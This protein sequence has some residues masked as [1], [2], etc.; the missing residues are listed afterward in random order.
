VAP[1]AG[2]GAGAG[3]VDMQALSGIVQ[4]QPGAMGVPVDARAR[5]QIENTF[6]LF[7]NML[8]SFVGC[9][10]RNAAAVL[11]R[12][13]HEYSVYVGFLNGFTIQ[14]PTDQRLEHIRQIHMEFY[15]NVLYEM[16]VGIQQG[17]LTK[18]EACRMVVD[19]LQAIGELY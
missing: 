9:H 13:S 4:P 5:R 19:F 1:G 6:T 14:Y 18:E 3:P 7:L 8:R 11:R 16:S 10:N 12:L 17:N 2:A 15:E